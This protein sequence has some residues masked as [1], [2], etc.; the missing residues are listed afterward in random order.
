MTLCEQVFRKMEWSFVDYELGVEAYWEAPTG[1][2]GLYGLP[3]IDSSWEVTAKYL[4]RFMREKGYEYNI[5]SHSTHCNQKSFEWLKLG[6]TEDMIFCV[7]SAEII[8]DKLPEAACK[9]FMEVKL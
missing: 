4:V 9:A 5:K 2:T 3:P 8:D 7:T 6:T 1:E